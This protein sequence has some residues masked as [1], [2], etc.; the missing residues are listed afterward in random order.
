MDK[1]EKQ[2]E[3]LDVRSGY[4]E[5][6]I[7]AYVARHSV[8]PA[9]F[10]AGG[11]GGLEIPF[12]QCLSGGGMGGGQGALVWCSF[13]RCAVSMEVLT[14]LTLDYRATSGPQACRCLPTQ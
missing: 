9:L 11:L 12:H 2:F 4:M 3:D 6:A 14:L 7:D 1:F 10:F 13:L 8:N 5:S